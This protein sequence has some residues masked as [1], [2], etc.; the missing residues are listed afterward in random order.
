MDPD[1]GKEKLDDYITRWIKERDLKPRTR[2]EYERSIRL[3]VR[4]YLGNVALNQITAQHIRTWRKGRLD[5]GIGGSTVAKT[6]RILH[7]I[8]VTLSTTM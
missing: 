7:A 5:A 3:H 1:A 2:E 4:P 6:Y 8:F